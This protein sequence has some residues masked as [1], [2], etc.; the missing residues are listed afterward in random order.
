MHHLHSWISDLSPRLFPAPPT[1][2]FQIFLGICEPCPRSRSLSHP[3]G[4]SPAE[5]FRH[6]APVALSVLLASTAHSCSLEMTTIVSI[7]IT[8]WSHHKRLE[9]FPSPLSPLIRNI[10]TWSSLSLLRILIFPTEFLHWLLLKSDH[11]RS[12]V[13]LKRSWQFAATPW[14]WSCQRVLPVKGE[15]FLPTVTKMLQFRMQPQVGEIQLYPENNWFLENLKQCSPCYI[16]NFKHCSRV[17]FSDVP[18]M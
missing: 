7:L 5:A 14:A 2:C 18:E 15:F 8:V 13:T 12:K 6:L 4:S 11:Q 16:I 1:A 17:C 3:L 10:L 9:F